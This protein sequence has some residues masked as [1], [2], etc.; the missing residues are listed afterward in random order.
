VID[1]FGRSI[2]PKPNIPLLYIFDDGT[3]EKKLF[4]D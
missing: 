4:V 1:I 3:I 2:T